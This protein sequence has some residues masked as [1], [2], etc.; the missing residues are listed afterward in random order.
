MRRQQRIQIAKFGFFYG[1]RHGQDQIM[2]DHLRKLCREC[3]TLRVVTCY[4]R[5]QAEEV[6][7]KDFDE[8][9]AFDS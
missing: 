9:G 8:K 3:K 2:Q 7:G 6:E 5:P 1:V 4:S